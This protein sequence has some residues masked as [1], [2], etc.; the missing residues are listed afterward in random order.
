MFLLCQDMPT[1]HQELAMMAYCVASC[2]SRLKSCT[3]TH[4]KDVSRLP[5]TMYAMRFRNKGSQRTY[6]VHRDKN[7]LLAYC[8]SLNVTEKIKKALVLSDLGLLEETVEKKE[9][10]A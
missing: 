5:T 10:L 2:T 1:Q 9:P 6:M 8:C 4:H 3:K 7:C